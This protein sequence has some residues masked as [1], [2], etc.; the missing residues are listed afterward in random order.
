MVAWKVQY[1]LHFLNVILIIVCIFLFLLL[2]LISFPS[3]YRASTLHAWKLLTQS[4]CSK[5]SCW[6]ILLPFESCHILP[7]LVLTLSYLEYNNWATFEV[8]LWCR[9]LRHFCWIKEKFSKRNEVGT[10][11]NLPKTTYYEAGAWSKRLNI[12]FSATVS[13]SSW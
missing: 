12:E 1:L 4:R 8:F 5:K 9:Y 7:C 10:I 6:C 2:L 11:I 3:Q 13:H